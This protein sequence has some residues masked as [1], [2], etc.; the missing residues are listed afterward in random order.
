MDAGP[1]SDRLVATAAG[2]EPFTFEELLHLQARVVRV[3]AGLAYTPVPLS[4][5]PTRL[6]GLLLHNV[7]LTRDKVDGLMAGLLKLVPALIGYPDWTMGSTNSGELLAE[8]RC[9]GL[10]AIAS[11]SRPTN[12]K[13]I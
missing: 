5:A 1:R 4:F 6:V 9:P 8:G 10:G 13:V 12:R 2:P 7:V 3:R 11:G